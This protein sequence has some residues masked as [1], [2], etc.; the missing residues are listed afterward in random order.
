MCFCL[1]QPCATGP[2]TRVP[3]A[4]GNV[5][6]TVTPASA[7]TIFGGNVQP[8]YAG[9]AGVFLRTTT[10]PATIT[11]TAAYGALSP[12]S[13]TLTTLQDTDRV[14]PFGATAVSA[15]AVPQAHSGAFFLTVTYTPK[16]L[17]VQCPPSLAGRLKI[18][19]CQ[20]R[21]VFAANAPPGAAVIVPRR[22]LG[23][24]VYYGVWDGGNRRAVSTINAAL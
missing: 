15:P 22:I 23:S 21:A 18:I 20:G 5:T 11:V 8:A 2:E 16:D 19:D 7:A 13:I 24:G 4:N 6:Y 12:A 9:R 17:L 1:P 14:P 10:V 3:L